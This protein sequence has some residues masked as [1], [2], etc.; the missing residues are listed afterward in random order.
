MRDLFR[1][2]NVDIRALNRRMK[3][4]MDQEGLLYNE[5]TSTFNSRLAQE[6]AKWAEGEAQ[7][8]RFNKALFRAYF[9]EG[10]NIGRPEAL[11]EIAENAGLAAPVAREVLETRRFRDAVDRD[12]KRCGDLEVTAVPTF[13]VRGSK[14]VGAQPYE[15]LERF[16]M[17]ASSGA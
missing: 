8:K 10:K 1:G 9:A 7:G 5:R 16:V 6:L 15:E 2:R 3:T 17:K 12:W 4:L 13:V 14:L 11:I